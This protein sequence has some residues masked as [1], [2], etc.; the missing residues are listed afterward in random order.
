MRSSTS[1]P[2]TAPSVARFST[3]VIAVSEELDLGIND[4][5]AMSELDVAR[6]TRPER[7]A[8]VRELVQEAH[9]I[10]ALGIEQHVTHEGKMVAAVVGL[11]SGGN[12]STV[13]MHVARDLLDC[14]AH[15]NTGIGIEQTRQFVR[16]TC[17]TWGIDLIERRAPNERDHYRNLVLTRQRGKKGQALGGFPGPAM[18]WKTYSRLKERALRVVQAEL[19]TS[20]HKERVVFVAGRRRTESKRRSAVPKHERRGAVV[21][22]SPMVNWTK[23]DLNTYRLMNPDCPVNETAALIHMSGECLC[24]AMASPGERAEISYWFPVAFEEIAELESLL[25]GRGDIPE[26][27]KTWGWGADPANKAAETE[28]LAQFEAGD[29]EPDADSVFLCRSCD[30]RFQGAFDFEEAS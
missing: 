6:L 4:P 18:H 30:D 11:F 7:E 27:R 25:A 5:L 1:N 22:I 9:D 13:L 23:A 20:S 3:G 14:A 26:H 19:L 10:I 15:A 17:E 16:D 28:Y 21:W 12:D 24:G 2:S 29:D 8:R